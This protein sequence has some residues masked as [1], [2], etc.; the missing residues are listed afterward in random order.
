MDE[1]ETKL[2][3]GNC[4]VK[5]LTDREIREKS[6]LAKWAGEEYDNKIA[7]TRSNVE[8]RKLRE[9]KAQAMIKQFHVNLSSMIVKHTFE[10]D[11]KLLDDYIGGLSQ[12]DVDKILEA[13]EV[14]SSVETDELTDLQSPSEVEES[15]NSSVTKTSSEDLGCN[16]NMDLDGQ[17]E[18]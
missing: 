17:S 14:A 4:L 15:Q 9:V 3:V 6:L 7:K 2:S 8:K 16:M 13:G 12:D 1:V 11:G 18:K 5:G 10:L